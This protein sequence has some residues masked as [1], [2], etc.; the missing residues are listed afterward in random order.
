M[1]LYSRLIGLIGLGGI[2]IRG[3]SEFRDLTKGPLP[4]PGD[5]RKLK[6]G[7]VKHVV[8][9]RKSVKLTALLSICPGG[10][11]GWFHATGITYPI[12]KRFTAETINWTP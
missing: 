4:V 8:K 3:S 2:D 12:R 11:H 5:K 7:R 9:R 10:S 6:P 1:S